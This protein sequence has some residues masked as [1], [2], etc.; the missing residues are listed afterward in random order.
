M[1]VDHGC[2]GCTDCASVFYGHVTS[3]SVKCP[4]ARYRQSSVLTL[5]PHSTQN[6]CLHSQNLQLC[7]YD[8]ECQ[9]YVQMPWDLMK[10]L[11]EC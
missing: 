2:S 10:S 11:K 7:T 6:M 9:G 4:C 3:V 8:T 5:G 1:Q